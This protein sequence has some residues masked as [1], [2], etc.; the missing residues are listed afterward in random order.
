MKYQEMETGA[1]AVLG[2]RASQQDAY[3]YESNGQM[4]LAAVCDGMGGMEGGEYASRCGILTLT[5]CFEQ[6]PPE[7][8]ETAGE[9]LR[10]AFAEADKQVASLAN[11][12]GECME[13]GSTAVAVLISEGKM[14]WGC[15]GD[16]SIYMLRGEQLELLTRMHNY[17]L[18]LEQMFQNGEIDEQE[19]CREAVRG[20]A[21]ISY[22]GIG[23]LPLM[24][25]AKAPI[26]L[27]KN[28]VILLCSDGLY[29]ALDMEQ[30][31]VII[32]ESGKNMNLAS[33]RLCEEARRLI[34]RQQDNTTVVLL[35]Y[36]GEENAEITEEKR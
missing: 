13:A 12:E 6:M 31:R 2:D 4:L 29:K 3:T 36:T 17:N 26:I 10:D 22:L 30:I 1:Y 15:V 8:V 11:A 34:T 21:L 27:Q 14:Q 28:D 19:R 25:T 23:N 5:K 16:S 7:S 20:E 35:R 9:W 32:E 18:T 33:K 24:D